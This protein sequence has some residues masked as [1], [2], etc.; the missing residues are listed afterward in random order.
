MPNATREPQRQSP[1][2]RFALSQ[3]AGAV[4]LM[5]GLLQG[6]AFAQSASEED[7]PLELKASPRLQETIPKPVREQLPTFMYGDRTSGRPDLETVLEGDA[8]LRRGDTVVKGDRIEYD[9]STVAR[10]V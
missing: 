6:A 1:T 10:S 2:G 9:Q 8:M 3:V 7:E 4:V 5:A